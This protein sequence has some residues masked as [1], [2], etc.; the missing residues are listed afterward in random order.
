M[1]GVEGWG[2]RGQ[3]LVDAVCNGLSCWVG[4]HLNFST[5]AAVQKNTA[6]AAGSQSYDSQ[7]VPG[8]QITVY[9]F[10]RAA[11]P[12]C[13]RCASCSKLWAREC[14]YGC[15]HGCSKTQLKHKL[16]AGQHNQ[17]VNTATTPAQR[18][19]SS[20]SG[21]EGCAYNNSKNTR[22]KMPVQTNPKTFYSALLPASSPAARPQADAA[23]ALV[24]AASTER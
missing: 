1:E 21:R 14:K 24:P 20:A 17:L 10:A 5:G 6:G 13:S 12:A 2:Q 19:L 3:W 15:Q 4:M 18:A 7:G 23:Q 8:L 11:S 22:T 16:T 9:S